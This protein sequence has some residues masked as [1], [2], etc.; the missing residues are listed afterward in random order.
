MLQFWQICR[1]A[2]DGDQ[3][4]KPVS[5]FFYGVWWTDL[6]MNGIVCDLPNQVQWMAMMYA[7]GFFLCL[8]SKQTLLLKIL[9]TFVY[10]RPFPLKISLFKLRN[11]VFLI[12]FVPNIKKN[13][14]KHFGSKKH[15]NPLQWSTISF[16]LS[17][18]TR[19][20]RNSKIF[21]NISFALKSALIIYAA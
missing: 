10:R 8:T 14:A 9:K 18:V 13:I 3:T 16:N 11:C 1:Q 20:Q 15:K 7:D 4:R 17:D 12:I 21:N 19:W 2:P 6:L 5:L